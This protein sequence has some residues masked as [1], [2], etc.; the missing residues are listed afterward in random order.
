[1]KISSHPYGLDVGDLPPGL[2]GVYGSDV[3][4]PNGQSVYL[5][6]A[7]LEAHIHIQEEIDCIREE[8]TNS[9]SPEEHLKLAV[10]RFSQ[11]LMDF[12]RSAA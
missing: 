7:S 3:V 12:V 5:R 1:M 10:D 6:G 8:M 9:I 2:S 11:K 4:L